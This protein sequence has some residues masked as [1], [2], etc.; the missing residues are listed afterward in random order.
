M[1]LFD[2]TS[3]LT[4]HFPRAGS[5]L[6]EL[7][8][9]PLAGHPLL[10]ALFAQR[11]RKVVRGLRSFLRFLVVPDIHIGDAVMSQ[12]ALTALRDFFP[13]AHVDYIV[14]RILVITVPTSAGNSILLK[15]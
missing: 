4:E 7:S 3:R 12:A 8:L 11:N 2:G 13:D 10:S 1:I 9:R 5:H 14:N 15:E 6:L